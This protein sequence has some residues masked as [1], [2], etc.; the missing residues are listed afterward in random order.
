MHEITAW[1]QCKDAV[2]QVAHTSTTTCQACE[3]K[4]ASG[5]LRLGVMYLHVDGF[6][7]VEWIHLRCQ[8]WRV[9]A[10]DSISFV[11]RGCL[12]VDQALHIRRWLVSCQTQLTESTASDIIAL[13]AWHVV[14]PLTTL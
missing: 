2:M 9:T 5:Q 4:I 7:L 13:E 1:S 11:D 6:M 10:F 3:G 8:P 12:S 14:M